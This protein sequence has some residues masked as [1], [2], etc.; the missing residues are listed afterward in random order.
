MV[1][2]VFSAGFALHAARGSYCCFLGFASS[3]S[4]KLNSSFGDCLGT[5][6]KH[7]WELGQEPHCYSSHLDS[8]LGQVMEASFF[9]QI[10]VS[11]SFSEVLIKLA[12][13]NKVGNLY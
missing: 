1:H 13:T 12:K 4:V 3:M 7:L 11:A 6:D 10:L 9:S 2:F 5:S 8:V